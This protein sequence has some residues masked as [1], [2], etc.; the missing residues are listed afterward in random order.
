LN[1]SCRNKN[2]ADRI[3]HFLLT[4]GISKKYTPLKKHCTLPTGKA[5]HYQEEKKGIHAADQNERIEIS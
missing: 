2:F 3:N 5:S 1:F 4:S